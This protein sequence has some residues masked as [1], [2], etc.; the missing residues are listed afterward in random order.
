MKAALIGSYVEYVIFEG[1]SERYPSWFQRAV[2]DDA[3]QE[4]EVYTFWLPEEERT[5]AYYDKILVDDWAVFLMKPDGDIHRTSYDTFTDLYT[6]FEWTYYTNSGI[7]AYGEDCIEYVECH[8]GKLPD[9][10]PDWFYEYFTE[11]INFPQGQETIFIYDTE[12]HKISASEQSHVKLD[13]F[14]MNHGQIVVTA[15]CVIL[16]NRFGE[17]RAMHYKE[18]LRHYDPGPRIWSNLESEFE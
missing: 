12:Q 14:V 18:F 8:G 4:A 15:H 13:W 17:L 10:Y 2:L 5:P 16:R 7:A 1:V 9:N 6:V 3:L 11:A